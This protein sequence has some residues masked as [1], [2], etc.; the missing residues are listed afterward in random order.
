LAVAV[1]AA[2]GAAKAVAAFT[3][4][5]APTVAPVACNEML[6]RVATC[7]TSTSATAK[8]VRARA[9]VAVFT[10]TAGVPIAVASH[11]S[12]KEEQS[13]LNTCPCKSG[14]VCTA[15]DAD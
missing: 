1:A 6:D 3:A 10:V 7:A 13:F 4:A 5:A 8:T 2:F 9:D 12:L 14:Y 15:D 11:A